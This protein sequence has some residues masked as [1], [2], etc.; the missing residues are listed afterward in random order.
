MSD[1]ITQAVAKVENEE[2]LDSFLVDYKPRFAEVLPSHV[3]ADT[4]MRL[5]T[6]AFRKSPKLLQAARNDPAALL[7]ALSEAARKGLEPGTEQFYLVPRR[8]K[9]V[10]KVQGIEGY[11]G[12][13]ERMYR[14]GYVASVVVVAVRENDAFGFVPGRDEKPIHEI[15][16]FGDR[17]ELI[18]AYGYANMRGGGVSNV[19]VLNKKQ[20]MEVK[21]QSKGAKSEYSPWNKWEE[22][23]WKKTVARRLERWVP[24]SSEY[25]SGGTQPADWHER[26]GLPKFFTPAEEVVQAEVLEAEEANALHY[27]EEDQ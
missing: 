26:N 5:A 3:S 19:V 17:G 10:E 9:G 4:F 24:V 27:D 20:V 14:A 11:Q 16:W 13:V 23:M 12:I 21:A 25:R 2:K 7:D 15:D 22:A 18:G 1:P 6:G 8:D